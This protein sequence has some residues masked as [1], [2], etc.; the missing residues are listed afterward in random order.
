MKRAQVLFL[1]V[2]VCVSLTGA[3]EVKLDVKEHTLA[4]G[5]RI[6]MIPKS[7]V[8]RVVCHIYDRVGSINERPGTTG[9]EIKWTMK[10][11]SLSP[12]LPPM[13]DKTYAGAKT[14][15]ITHVRSIEKTERNPKVHVS[16]YCYFHPPDRFVCLS[17]P[18]RRRTA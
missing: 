17:R 16:S 12:I 5:L 6:L 15:R 7:G 4:N 18:F 11:S 13:Y 9:E 10:K 3:A 14:E 8:P 2:L 1:V